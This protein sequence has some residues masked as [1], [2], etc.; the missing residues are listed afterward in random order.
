MTLFDFKCHCSLHKVLNEATF[1][2]SPNGDAKGA[3]TA[4]SSEP[5]KDL[6][7]YKAAAMFT[8]LF[9]YFKTLSIGST[10]RIESRTFHSEDQHSINKANPTTVPW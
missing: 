1:F 9:S 4:W 10:P 8:I 5:S 3:I 2:T 7:V 6:F